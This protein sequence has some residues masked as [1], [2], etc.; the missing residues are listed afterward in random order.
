MLKNHTA[1]LAN[2]EPRNTNGIVTRASTAVRNR[3][4]PPDKRI[5]RTIPDKWRRGS[6]TS[7][8]D[9]AP[10]AKEEWEQEPVSAEAV[11]VA[12][13]NR[14][15]PRH[16]RSP[17]SRQDLIPERDQRWLTCSYY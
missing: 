4:T 15:A 16:R 9:V 5:P 12:A 8:P 3:R 1:G 17:C 13:A 11:T 6:G 7:V 14:A 2:E 10:S